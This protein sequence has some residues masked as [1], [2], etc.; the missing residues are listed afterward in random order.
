MTCDAKTFLPGIETS[1]FHGV[2]N[3]KNYSCTYG[4]RTSLN[5]CSLTYSDH[6]KVSL[7]VY[8]FGWFHMILRQ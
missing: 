3:I 7:F 1:T 5:R 4:K 6:C 2:E 8:S